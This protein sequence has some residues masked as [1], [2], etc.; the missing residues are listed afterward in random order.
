M[1]A[2]SSYMIAARCATPASGPAP[3]LL[4]QELSYSVHFACASLWLS[5]TSSL[6]AA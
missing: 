2:A 4:L 3:K 5:S 1:S 6:Y